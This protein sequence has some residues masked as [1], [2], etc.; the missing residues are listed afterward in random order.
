MFYWCVFYVVFFFFQAEDGIRD[1]HVTG[2]QTCALPGPPPRPRSVR[3]RRRAWFP[4]A[5][6]RR[7][8]SLFAKADSGARK[9]VRTRSLSRYGVRSESWVSSNARRPQ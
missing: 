9:T 1:G 5:I 6:I 2:V 8:R 3:I 7:Q 4:S